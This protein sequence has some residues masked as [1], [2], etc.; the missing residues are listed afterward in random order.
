LKK[1]AILFSGE[2]SN[3]QT[4]IQKLHKKSFGDLYVEVATTITNNP[5]A[6]GIKKAKALDVDVQILDHQEFKTREEYDRTLVNLILSLDIDLVVLAGFMRIL[7][8]I[9]TDNITAINIHPS[10]LPDFKGADA[11]RRSYNSDKKIV[12]VTTH[13]VNAEL[14]GGAIIDQKSFDKSGMSF[15]E[16]TSNIH[17]CEYEIFAPSILKALT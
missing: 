16:F 17:K 15:E 12:G 11:L 7:T 8:P 14:D 4:L 9:F 13:F 2:G 3:M 6:N 10:L 5:N 1:I